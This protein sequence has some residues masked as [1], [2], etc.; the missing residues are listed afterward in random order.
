VEHFR[1]GESRIAAAVKILTVLDEVGLGYLSLG[2]PLT[3]LSGGERQRLKLAVQLSAKTA[4]SAQVIIL[5]EPTTGLHLADVDNLL[6]L[7]DDLVDAGRTVIVIEH[8]Q[9]VMA[10]ADH[11]ID[12]GPGAGHDGGRIVFEGSPTEL[13][14]AASEPVVSLAADNLAAYVS[15]GPRRGGTG[16]SQ[17]RG[18]HDPVTTLRRAGARHSGS[19]EAVRRGFGCRFG[20]FGFK[21][22]VG[23]VTVYNSSV[24]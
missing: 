16:R 5:D 17:G 2:Q 14:A 11:I 12:L 8:H 3:T 18:A 20:S 7:L 13:V 15:K 9:A 23:F 10:H 1:A 4:D 24:T 19:A 22:C 21:Q 6:R